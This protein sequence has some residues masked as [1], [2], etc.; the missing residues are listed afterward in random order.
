MEDEEELTTLYSTVDNLCESISGID[1]DLVEIENG[2]YA[3]FCFSPLSLRWVTPF[4]WVTPS[5][6]L[7][8]RT[9]IELK[10]EGTHT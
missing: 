6:L 1:F 5:P 8:H 3:D 7:Q 10:V 9:T 2:V 4:T